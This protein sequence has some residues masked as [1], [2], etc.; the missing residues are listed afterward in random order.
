[1]AP[2]RRGPILLLRRGGVMVALVA[3]ALVA[4]LPA[5]AA[6]PFLSSSRSATLH[7]QIAASCQWTLGAGATGQLAPPGDQAL[8]GGS[9]NLAP[10]DNVAQVASRTAKASAAARSVPLLGS[11][12]TTLFT[13]VQGPSEV[14]GNADFP[15]YLIART[16]AEN[17]L[18][19]LDGPRGTGVWISDEYANFVHLKVG[20]QI[21]LYG[22]NKSTVTQ[23]DGQSQVHFSGDQFS[24]TLPVAAVYRDLRD[25]PDD[26][27][28]CDLK[29]V[30][31]GPQGNAA[32]PVVAFVDQAAFLN[33]MP[34]LHLSA[35]QVIT[36]PLTD[37]NLNQDQARRTV[38]GVARFNKA[39]LQSPSS[40]F[41]VNPNRPGTPSSSG[42]LLAQFS[43][44][45]DL[46]RRSM[47]PAVVP[48]TA[49][50]VL[51][52]LLV[53]AAAAMFWVQ[54]RRRELTLLSAHG[55]SAKAL[56]LKAVAESLPALVVGTV[57]GWGAAWG[58]VRWVGPDPVLSREAAPWAAVGAA[59]SL[60]AA[61]LVV[62]LVAGVACRSLTDQV[63][64]HHHRR[65][66]AVPYELVLLAAALP[67][68]RALGD[69][70]VTGNASNG[71]G[72]A[73]HVPGRLLIVPIMVV[74]GVT[75][76]AARLSVT[77]LRRRG[78][79]RT[80]RTPAAFLSWRRIGRQA[81]MTA[82]LAGAT[83]VP[84]ALAI[85]G[86]TVTGSVHTTVADEARL[87]V[88]SDV[89]LTLTH[90]VPIPAS[91]RGQATEVLRLDGAMIGGVQTDLL[92]VDPGSFAR[93]A[94]WDNRLDGASLSDLMAPIRPGGGAGG[95]GGGAGGG[96]GPRTVVA[97][98]Q[99]PSGSQQATWTGD[100][101]L[102]GNVNIVS[103]NLLPAQRTG[104]PA[105]LVP[106]AALGD[107]T[108]YAA[109]QLWVRGDPVQ[110]Q[111][112][113]KAANLP[114][115][116]I[117]VASDLYSNS[118]WEPLTYTF[119]YLTAL[120]LL[121]GLVTLVGLLLYLEAQ[122]PVHRR[123]YVLLRRMGLTPRSH[124]RAILGELALPLIAGLIGGVVVAGALAAAL[125]GNYDLN[126]DQPP[127]TVIAVPY[128]PVGL[129]AAAVVA[130]AIGAASYAQRRIGRANPSEVLRD[131]I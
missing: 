10:Q 39:L 23:V 70:T 118:L 18:Q 24:T 117:L 128:L 87:R 33:A 95:G 106:K 32:T 53:V 38:A 126:P 75:I 54:R 14:A 15:V 125:S 27:W 46:A 13:A 60:V 68:W 72:T 51:V 90:R 111:R 124:R 103:T 59:G 71:L 127:D 97:S 76:L 112:A 122:A 12:E 84:I 82:V 89:V 85:Y 8:R 110:I 63:R 129:I 107:D 34:R 105:A 58:L 19:V 49:A 78:I 114:V 86:A 66:R 35:Q 47:L 88:G 80:P 25:L 74:A 6:T 131:A 121:T 65:L 79:R 101:V 41:Y 43:A 92:G 11:A 94:Y 16:G 108:Q 77:Y 73:I 81:V 45:A 102:G 22:A 62:A 113:A 130:I 91:L 4:T 109:V 104:Y 93:D 5:A 67:V 98:A 115:K 31:D 64:S 20:D 9:G 7:H 26:P 99:T 50:G 28:W 36:F 44:R 120:S 37:P 55:V 17:H 40:A 2:W 56:A 21:T 119:E 1:M 3:A 30:Y 48:V 96:G 83:S 57:A 69:S 123:A 29:T 116:E 100:E 42:S 61:V 52:G